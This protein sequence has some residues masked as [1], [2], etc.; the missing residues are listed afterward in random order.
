MLTG[1]W[2]VD[3]NNVWAVGSDGKN[4]AIRKWNGVAWSAQDSGTI[5]RFR[6]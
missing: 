2:G 1:I 4:G 6:R 3:S 5:G